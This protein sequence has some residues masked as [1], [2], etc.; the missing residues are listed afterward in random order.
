[1]PDA[2]RVHLLLPAC[3]FDDVLTDTFGQTF[4]NALI[5]KSYAGL[6]DLGRS[7]LGIVDGHFSFLLVVVKNVYI[8]IIYS[9]SY[10]R[11]VYKVGFIHGDA[12]S[13]VL[14]PNFAGR[15]SVK[16]KAPPVVLAGRGLPPLEE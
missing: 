1:L 6:S 13:A 16:E 11:A 10:F 4:A 12:G 5:G 2:E 15:K 14:L 3:V 7:L 8:F 9:D